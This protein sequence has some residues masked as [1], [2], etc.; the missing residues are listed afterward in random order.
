VPQQEPAARAETA[1]VAPPTVATPAPE[2]AAAA[3]APESGALTLVEVRRLWP[4]IVEATKLRR[5]VTWMHLTQ[6]CQVISV[7]GKVLTL[8][9]SNA[10]AR[11]SFDNGGSAE[12][13]RQAAIDVV[14]ADWRVVTIVDPGAKADPHAPRVITPS[15]PAAPD[16]P[17]AGPQASAPE[18]PPAWATEQPDGAPEP[19]RDEI[20]DGG[21]GGAEPAPEQVAPPTREKAGP[22][23][24]AAAKAA[25]Q[26]TR[27]TGGGEPAN[28]SD[29]LAAADAD[30]HPDDIDADNQGLAGTE[31][32]ERE[33]G[34][35]VIE[36]I[37]NQ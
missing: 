11:E 34:A 19:P 12:I 10:G 9:F 35:R 17:P 1:P 28:R 22:E 24:I 36:E 26:Q 8:G 21:S 20:H 18:S 16:S 30:A 3:A 5:R 37:R 7:E 6:N 14:G 2:P 29:S 4:D 23:A 31:L 25:I 13:V 32:L 33:L 27:Q 15:T